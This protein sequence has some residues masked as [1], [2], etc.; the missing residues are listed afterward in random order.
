MLVRELMSTP[1]VTVRPDAS[2]KEAA[3]RLT[4]HGITAMPVVDGSGALL[5]VISEADVIRDAVLPDQ[6]AHERPVHL[7]DGPYGTRVR[8]VMSHFPLSVRTD[9][10]L[11]A[12]AE[13]M[14]GT[15]VKSLPVVE[16]G[17]VVG[18]ISRRDIVAVLAR[19]D[20][21]IEGEV[22]ELLRSAGLDVSVEVVDGVV[23][24]DGPEETH[25]QEMA[26]VLVG[27]VQGVVGVRFGRRPAS[28]G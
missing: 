11:A 9:A 17:V 15:A 26:R 7:A 27:T 4:E 5:G 2:I 8:D 22:D 6:R 21:R 12:A 24:L 14:T 1:A 28:R 23:V 20:Q 13:L 18:M 10:D 3:R 19:S 16:R 25:Q